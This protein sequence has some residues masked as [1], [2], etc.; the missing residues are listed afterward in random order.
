MISKEEVRHVAKL[1]R[2]SISKKDEEKF[3]RELS[4]ILDYFD[5]LKRVNVEGILPTHHIVSIENVMRKDK[6]KRGKKERV[7]K[8][9]KAAIEKQDRYFKVKPIL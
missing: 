8:L 1:A 6:V 3:Q 2:I 5:L 4:S 9:I 7:D